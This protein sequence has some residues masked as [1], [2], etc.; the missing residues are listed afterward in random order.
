MEY[1]ISG[2]QQRFINYASSF[3]I[4][5]HYLNEEAKIVHLNEFINDI[6]TKN[7]T[8]KGA[9]SNI[10]TSFKSQC[11]GASTQGL[12]QPDYDMEQIEE[13]LRYE[14]EQK[15]KRLRAEQEEK[16][17]RAEEA[18][19]KLQDEFEMAKNIEDSKKKLK[20]DISVD[21]LI[22]LYNK[23]KRE[24]GMTLK[25]FENEYINAILKKYKDLSKTEQD[26]KMARG[27]E[28][29]N[30]FKTKIA[31]NELYP[32]TSSAVE[33]PKVKDITF[34]RFKLN[35][36]S[37]EEYREKRKNQILNGKR[38]MLTKYTDPIEIE[39]I[40][41]L[42]DQQIKR[43]NVLVENQEKRFK[44]IKEEE[45]VRKRILG[46]M[47]EETEIIPVESLGKLS[48]IEIMDK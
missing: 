33:I 16:R 15:E 14:E 4:I 27:Q 47:R 5:Q 13:D 36:E 46:K 37:V 10:Y 38:S 30:I 41:L 18:R 31:V 40:D 9:L 26:E 32:S 19:K 25:E 48:D 11:I 23:K 43:S 39:N 21:K 22:I 3:L 2:E 20:D 45:Q 7:I 24:N 8:S 29:L 12:T 44:I 34:S 35:I 42:I 28:L 1:V 6:K 17:L